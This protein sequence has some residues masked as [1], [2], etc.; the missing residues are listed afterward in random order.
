LKRDAPLVIGGYFEDED[1]N[2]PMPE[3]NIATRVMTPEETLKIALYQKQRINNAWGA[4]IATKIFNGGNQSLRFTEGLYYEDLEIF[5]KLCL[6][7][8]KIAYDP[9]PLYFYRQHP[10]SFIHT[11]SPRRLDSLTVTNGILDLVKEKMPQLEPAAQDRQ[12]SAAFNVLVLL[13]KYKPDDVVPERYKTYGS[14]YGEI[15]GYCMSVIRHQRK[16]SIFDRNVRLK[17]KIGAIASFGG[18]PLL[19]LLATLSH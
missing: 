16:R 17:N 19:R 5:P 12:M 14:T 7:A 9:E 1:E 18:R 6:R 11:F 3:K 2:W 8:E 15:A 10:D 4:L 13:E